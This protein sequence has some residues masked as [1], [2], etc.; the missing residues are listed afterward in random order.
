VVSFR[1]FQFALLIQE[2][3]ADDNLIGQVLQPIIPEPDAADDLLD[4]FAVGKLSPPMA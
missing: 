1:G 4:D 3:P 2:Y